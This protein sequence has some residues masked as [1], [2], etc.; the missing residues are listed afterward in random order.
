MPW[1]LHHDM[2]A[3]PGGK[4]R[5]RQKVD[6]LS[7][8]AALAGT[9]ST[10]IHPGV[11]A[12]ERLVGLDR[13]A[14]RLGLGQDLGRID[15]ASSH[16]LDQQRDVF[17]MVAIAHVD[18]EIAVH[19]LADRKRRSGRRI[20]ADDRQ[21]SRFGQRIDRPTQGLRRRIARHPILVLR[22]G[23]RRYCRDFLLEAVVFLAS[24]LGRSVMGMLG[25]DAD[26]VDRA[27]DTDLAGQRKDGLDRILRVE[28]HDRRALPPR[29]RE[30]IVLVV[31]RDDPACA[32]QPGAGNRELADRPAA[33]YCD[34]VARLDLRHLRGEITGRENVRQQDG[35]IVASS[36]GS[37][38]NPTLANGRRTFS[39]CMPGKPP[40]SAGPPKNAVP[41]RLPLGLALSHYA[42]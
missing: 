32:H 30:P 18:G 4:C 42:K 7:Y 10:L 15:G 22:M 29:H 1:H 37:F 34:R 25:I 36:S 9:S 16:E 26:R 20:D 11:A 38:T 14:Q 41:A 28:I 6:H 23:F 27:V 39:A 12:V 31:D 2:N 5:E 8:S 19:R 13:T 33:E 3:A 24:G 40:F 21:G 35:L 17:A